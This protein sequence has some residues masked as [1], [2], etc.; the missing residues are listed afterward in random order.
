MNMI[1]KVQPDDGQDASA[2]AARRPG[3]QRG[4]LVLVPLALVVGGVGLAN[5]E[6]P[7]LFRRRRRP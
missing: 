4:A 6:P 1:S 2:V 3:W 7:P 5:R